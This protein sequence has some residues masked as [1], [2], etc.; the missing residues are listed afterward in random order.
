MA[1]AKGLTKA[2]AWF[3][4]KEPASSVRI[5]KQPVLKFVV[6]FKT[7]TDANATSSTTSFEKKVMN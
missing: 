7:G 6:K 2:E 4:L 1:N 3:F 5:E